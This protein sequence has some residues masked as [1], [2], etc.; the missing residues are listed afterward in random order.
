MENLAPGN[1]KLIPKLPIWSAHYHELPLFCDTHMDQSLFDLDIDF[2]WS[3]N[4]HFTSVQFLFD[5]INNI[6]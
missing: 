6:R 4:F 2:I 1:I 3:P 5:Q